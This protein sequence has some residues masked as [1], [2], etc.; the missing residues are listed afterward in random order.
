MTLNYTVVSYGPKTQV[1]KGKKKKQIKQ[2][3]S[4]LNLVLKNMPSRSEKIH[5][6]EENTYIWHV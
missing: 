1:I 5:R 6:I 3:I 2:T 4:H